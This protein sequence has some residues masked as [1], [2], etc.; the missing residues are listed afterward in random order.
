MSPTSL[1]LDDSLRIDKICATCESI[2]K[3]RICVAQLKD[4]N[5]AS[6]LGHIANGRNLDDVIDQWT[7]HYDLADVEMNSEAGC[8]LCSTFLDLQSNNGGLEFGFEF[9][10]EVVNSDSP[11]HCYVV[12][13]LNHS[14]SR[15]RLISRTSKLIEM[16]C[17]CPRITSDANGRQI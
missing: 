4:N 8:E 13:D 14:E 3:N 16:H 9:F 11:H 1:A 17:L 2:G 15:T 5:H 6:C 10:A 7:V 12:M